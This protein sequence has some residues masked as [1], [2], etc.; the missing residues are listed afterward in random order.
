[1]ISHMKQTQLVMAQI[2]DSI[3]DYL[4]EELKINSDAL[5]P[6]EGDKLLPDNTS[7]EVLKIREIEALKLRDRM[8][9]L[10][11]HIAVIKRMIPV[12]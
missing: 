8:H 9:E 2:K 12:K 6:Y 3:I 4:T 1:M 10:T 11:R 7:P 5:K